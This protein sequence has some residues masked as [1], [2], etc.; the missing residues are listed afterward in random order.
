MLNIFPEWIWIFN[1]GPCTSMNWGICLTLD[2][3][4]M[5]QENKQGRKENLVCPR[6]EKT[7][8]ME[9]IKF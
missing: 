8:T 2:N 3:Y 5:K 6:Q 4:E 1:A 9:T 7:Q